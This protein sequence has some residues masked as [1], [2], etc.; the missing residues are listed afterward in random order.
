MIV[1]NRCAERNEDTALVCV[2]CGYKLQSQ[3][4]DRGVRLP[5][6]EPLEPMRTEAGKGGGL[7]LHAALT[8]LL[9]A[10]LAVGAALWAVTGLWWPAAVAA[11]A[12]LGGLLLMRRSR[13]GNARR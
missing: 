3:F 6:P 7:F 9:A 12:G 4:V 1:C 5:R 11:A 8:V 13:G 10:G 2:R